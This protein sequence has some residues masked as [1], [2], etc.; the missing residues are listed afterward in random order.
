MLCAAETSRVDRRTFSFVAACDH[1]ALTDV[2]ERRA[3]F[4]SWERHKMKMTVLDVLYG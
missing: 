3:Q 1:R 2:L 4:T